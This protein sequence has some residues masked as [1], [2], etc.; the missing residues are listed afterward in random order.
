MIKQKLFAVIMMFLTSENFAKEKNITI[1]PLDITNSK[2]YGF[3]EKFL[4]PMLFLSIDAIYY[5]NL[6]RS[7]L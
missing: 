4:W 1:S 3:R 6:I 2:T 7:L 5:K